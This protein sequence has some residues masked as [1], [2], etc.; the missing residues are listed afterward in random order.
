ML[1][2]KLQSGYVK[3]LIYT[4]KYT[5]SAMS[6]DYS[7]HILCVTGESPNKIWIYK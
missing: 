6:N 4:Y 1:E 5:M 3:M 7:I 2:K